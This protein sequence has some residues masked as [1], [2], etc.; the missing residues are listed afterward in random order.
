[1]LALFSP[2]AGSGVRVVAALIDSRMASRQDIVF[3]IAYATFTL[4]RLFPWIV[5][6]RTHLIWYGFGMLLLTLFS[7]PV[8]HGDR[9][10]ILLH[11]THVQVLSLVMSLGYFDFKAA[12]FWNAVQDLAQAASFSFA[13]VG[14]IQ[15]VTVDEFWTQR[16]Y[17]FSEKALALYVV[18]R[19]LV[20]CMLREVEAKQEPYRTD[21]LARLATIDSTRPDVPAALATSLPCSHPLRTLCGMME[22][23]IDL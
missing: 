14:T 11:S 17:T 18:E 23:V 19:L 8:I 15:Q 22:S 13:N 12:F 16:F 20:S 4:C 6:M 5:N 2:G 7:S 21:R 3:A 10:L 9:E 1:M